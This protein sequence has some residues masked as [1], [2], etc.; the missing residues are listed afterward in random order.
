MDQR[1]RAAILAVLAVGIASCSSRTGSD[2][3]T[4]DSRDSTAAVAAT[5]P[6]ERG[7]YLARVSG[8][9]DCHTPGTLY[10]APDMKRALSGS[11]LGWKGP[12]G[13][14]YPNNLTPDAATGLGTWTDEEIRR[15]IQNGVR[16]NGSPVAPPMPWPNFAH[17]TRQDAMA[18]IAYLRSIPAV[19]HKVPDRVPPNGTP[20]GPVL[21]FPP[22]PAWDVPSKPAS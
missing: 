8:C 14:S 5:T 1:F 4:T 7:A 18:I 19:V 9:H 11:D 22:P 10:G 21:D 3:A 2:T 12:W 6:I 16:K 15:A 20:L 17:F 13:V